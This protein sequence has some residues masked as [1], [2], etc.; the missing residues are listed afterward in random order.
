MSNH[1]LPSL[2]PTSGLL[3]VM[4]NDE[5]LPFTVVVCNKLV[6]ISIVQYIGD[7]RFCA[8]CCRYQYCTVRCRYRYC[9]V[10]CQYWY[11]AMCCQYRYCAGCCRQPVLYN[12][13]PILC[14]KMLML[15]TGIVQ[16]VVD[17]LH[18]MQYVVN[19]ITGIVQCFGNVNYRYC[20]ICCSC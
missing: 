12:V 18:I 3:S 19:V 20:A 14:S 5:R 9:T 17:H 8:I 16:Y 6:I 13:L 2:L 1:I 7:C 4:T 10:R 15:I 11:C